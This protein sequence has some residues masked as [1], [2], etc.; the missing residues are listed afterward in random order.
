MSVDKKNNSLNKNANHILLIVA[1]VSPSPECAL[2][3]HGSL[4][5]AILFWFIQADLDAT[6][7]RLSTASQK[8]DTVEADA[9]KTRF[10]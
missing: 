8:S 4:M 3:D 7:S 2:L 6:D 1:L 9:F 5:Q 10:L